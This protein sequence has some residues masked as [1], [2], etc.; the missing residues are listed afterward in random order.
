[1][2][3]SDSV[4]GRSMGSSSCDNLLTV[5]RDELE[6]K[7]L[8]G[9]KG[10]LMQ[11]ELVTAFIDEFHKQVNRQRAE[12]DGCRT[13]LCAISRRPNVKSAG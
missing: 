5:R 10:Q 8:D 6:A 1:M 13:A 4:R 11:P 12:Q 7:V 9:L 3:G 2:E